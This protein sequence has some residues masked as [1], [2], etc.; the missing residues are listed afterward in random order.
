MALT[1]QF[2][3]DAALTAAL[4]GN[5][6]HSKLASVGSEDKDFRLYLG[7]T[8]SGVKLTRATNPGVNPITVSVSDSDAVND[9][10][11]T[12]VKLATTQL[13]LDTAVGGADLDL[14]PEI[15]SGTG[16]AVAIWIRTTNDLSG[17]DSDST[18]GILIEDVDEVPQ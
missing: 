14:D 12:N 13:G 17:V 15:L 1:F 16:G 4:S 3:T 9:P 5:L 8:T 10:P 18:L 11:D 7:S 2:Y 6:Q